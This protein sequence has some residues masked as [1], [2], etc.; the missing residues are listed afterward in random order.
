VAGQWEWFDAAMSA[1]LKPPQT[2]RR[3]NPAKKAKTS[4]SPFRLG[5]STLVAPMVAQM[6]G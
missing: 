2:H 6:N 4:G 1:L 3:I 5:G